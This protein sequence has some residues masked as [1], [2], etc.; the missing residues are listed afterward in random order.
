MDEQTKIRVSAGIL[1]PPKSGLNHEW[2]P[3]DIAVRLTCSGVRHS[4]VLEP[5][6]VYSP[7]FSSVECLDSSGI[8]NGHHPQ[9][10][11]TVEGFLKQCDRFRDEWTGRQYSQMVALAADGLPFETPPYWREAVSRA[12]RTNP[13]TE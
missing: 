11:Y 4:L 13:L 12:T 7:H 6:K 8:I 9:D 5:V 10:M 2:K 1:F 3:G